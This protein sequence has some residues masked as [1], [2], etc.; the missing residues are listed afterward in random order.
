MPARLVT[1]PFS[2]YCEKARWA[3]ERAGVEF[4]EDAH[5]PIFSYLPLIRRRARRTV[6]ALITADGAVLPDSTDILRWCDQHGTGPALYPPEHPDAASLEDDFDRKLGPATRRVAYFHLLASKAA[7]TEV[8]SKNVPSW[9]RKVGP[10]VRPLAASMIRRGLKI[11]A[12]GAE[13]SRATIDDLFARVAE[14][15]ADGRRYLCGD[16]FTA[17]DL[18]F[19]ALATPL[20]APDAFA[21][22][23]L[24]S[25]EHTPPA[26][27]AVRDH[28]RATPAGQ[29]V[30]R[31][32]QHDRTARA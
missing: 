31:L 4:I 12:A 7:L 21:A 14:R 16:R 18:T 25:I 2:H 19:A 29:L 8:M 15:L 6:P 3:L 1:I 23:Y 30:E 13:R 9:E 17:A 5:L 10:M 28:Y 26:F 32:Y 22:R 24:P 11:D 20:I 27:I